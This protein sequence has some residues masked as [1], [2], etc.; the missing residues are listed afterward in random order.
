MGDK[1]KPLQPCFEL[2]YV[3]VLS[4]MFQNYEH[5]LEQDWTKLKHIRI[6]ATC[7]DM[8]MCMRHILSA[9]K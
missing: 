2:N 5:V 1:R 6:A 8:C 3:S 4:T 9:I 7:E